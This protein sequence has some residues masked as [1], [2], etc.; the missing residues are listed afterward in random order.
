MS[1]G[2][3]VATTT[4]HEVAK[5]SQ[6]LTV[7]TPAVDILENDHEILVHAEMPGVLKDDIVIHIDNG[8]L[9]VSGERKLV[10][11][12]TSAWQEFGDVEFR[13]TFAI[14]QTIDVEKVQAH[15]KDGVLE[16]HLSKSE[17][18]KPRQIEIQAN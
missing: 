12:G 13:R 7:V 14:P 8:K 2:K 5:P 16:L 3:D 15:L 9:F 17:T 6:S 10:S 11:T 4:Q 18:A 1:T